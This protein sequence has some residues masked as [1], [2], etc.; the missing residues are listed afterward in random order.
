MAKK[1]K[2]KKKKASKDGI[3]KYLQPY[4]SAKSPPYLPI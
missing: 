1:R 3:S 2:W 4:F